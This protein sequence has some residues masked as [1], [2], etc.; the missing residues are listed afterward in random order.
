M[1]IGSHAEDGQEGDRILA[2]TNGFEPVRHFFLMRR[3]LSA[4]IPEVPL[5]D[6]MELR[7]VTPDQHRTIYDAQIEAFR[8]HWGRREGS[9]HG[10]QATYARKE[11]DTALWAVAWSGDEVAGVVE[12]WIW[13]DEN[14]QLGVERGWL[15][16]VSVRRPFRRKGLARA[17]VAELLRRFRD[18]GM[19]DGMLGVDATNPLGAL[20]LYE[21]VGFEIERR[22]VAYRRTDEPRAATAD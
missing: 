7:P 3:D 5:P 6:G 10:F 2:E 20:P 14:A 8:D 9:E 17:L 16:K 22:E 13:A 4:P 12:N 21:G 19:T 1:V 11:L 15:E 18:A